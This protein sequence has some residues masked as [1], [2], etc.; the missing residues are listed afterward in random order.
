MVPEQIYTFYTDKIEVKAS[1]ND[2]G[3]KEYYVEGYASTSD[4]DLVNDV[5]TPNGLKSMM[6]QIK[7][8]QVTVKLD[9]EHETHQKKDF[10]I[11]STAKIVDARVDSKGLWIKA[12]LN[13]S[14]SRFKEVWGSIK[15]GFLDAF[16][17]TY[18]NVKGIMKNVEGKMVRLIDDLNLLNIAFTGTPVNQN[19]R[20]TSVMVKSLQTNQIEGGDGKMTEE[21]IKKVS[22][23]SEGEAEDAEAPQEEKEEDAQENEA[24]VQ[25]EAKSDAKKEDKTDAV[26]VKALQREVA[27]LKSQLEKSQAEAKSF[28]NKFED[29]QKKHDAIQEALSKPQIKALVEQTPIKEN[30]IAPS[31]IQLAAMRR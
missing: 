2:A 16:S 15:G 14:I 13:S 21:E 31:P 24:E 22:V 23:K 26:D 5:I 29:L 9:V 7:G 19:A 18:S 17:I 10:D 27:E 1:E 20:I 12:K 8:R 4:L 25:A 3:E 28:G 6:R 11:I 30:T